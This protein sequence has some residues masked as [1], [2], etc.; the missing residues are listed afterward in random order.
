MSREVFFYLCHRSAA[1]AAGVTHLN[2]RLAFYGVQKISY[3]ISPWARNLSIYREMA[4]TARNIS[5]S[6]DFSLLSL[7]TSRPEPKSYVVRLS[8]P[9]KVHVV[10]GSDL[11]Y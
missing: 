7:R 10:S 5:I 1:H 6:V 3:Y 11:S 2:N 4:L 9:H 8:L